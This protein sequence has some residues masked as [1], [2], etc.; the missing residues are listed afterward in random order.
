MLPKYKRWIDVHYPTAH[1]AL[2]KC[3]EASAEMNEAFPELR[4]AKGAVWLQGHPGERHHAWLVDSQGEVIDP[5]QLQYTCSGHIIAKREEFPKDHPAFMY[6]RKKC[7][8]CG[9]TFY[10]DGAEGKGYVCSNECAFEFE[11]WCNGS[12]EKDPF[13]LKEKWST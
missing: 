3:M 6:P 10:L 4:I 12:K 13:L 11:E 9:K 5:T 2:G 1:E 7:P 8:N